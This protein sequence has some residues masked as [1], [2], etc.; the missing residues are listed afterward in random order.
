MNAPLPPEAVAVAT[1]PV[2]QIQPSPSNPRKYFDE[3]YIAELAESI[4]T[5]G[6]IQPITV[7]PHPLDTNGLWPY[8]LVV[9]ECR[10]RAAKLAG[11]TDIPAF[12]R[13]LDDKQVLET[14]IIENLNRRDVTPLEEAEGYRRLMQEYGHTADTIATQIGKS[15]SHV[16]ARLKLLELCPGAI[17]YF[18]EGKL[19]ASTALLVARI[20]NLKLQE[21]AAK[22][23]SQ[24]WNG[25][26]MSYRTAADHV[27]H[28]Y[29]LKLSD[30]PFSRADET[31]LPAAGRCH[32]CPKRT[33]NDHDLFADVKS[34][35]MCTDPACFDA[36]KAAHVTAQKQRA[37]ANGCKIIEGKDAEKIKPHSYSLD[38]AGGYV[39]LDQKIHYGNKEVTLR[40]ALG[41]DAPKPDL[42]IDPHDKSKV[43]EVLAKATVAEQLKAKG[44][45]SPKEALARGGRSDKE[46]EAARKQKQEATYRQR[47]F[48]QIRSQLTVDFASNDDDGGPLKDHEY[49]LITS[50]LFGRLSFDEQKRIVRL[51]IGPTDEKQEDH[52]LIHELAKRI[53]NMERKDCC[54]LLIEL[55]LVGEVAVNSWSTDRKPE[56]MLAMAA[57]MQIDAAAIKTTV[58]AELREK[59]KGKAKPAAS[60][61]ASPPSGAAQAVTKGPRKPMLKPKSDPAPALPANEPAAPVEPPA[62]KPLAHWPFPND[63]PA[64]ITEDGSAS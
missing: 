54:R 26:P 50:C 38:L 3:A 1:L 63:D 35:D 51:W 59:Q 48:D 12:W 28:R 9:G 37:K 24:Q 2:N 52:A 58:I 46:K 8:Q 42:L 45:E 27:Q 33:G 7:R 55:S 41:K 10:W 31:L 60:Q 36:K 32:D 15:R 5:H 62:L 23:I 17:K 21:Q 19:D 47:L 11:L 18:N 56:Q 49:L 57:A 64:D 25:E 14:Q 40:Q 34:P 16:Y 4:K 29:M 44:I 30:A 43:I 6:L 53:P 22:E 20:G 61:K 13:E 39:A